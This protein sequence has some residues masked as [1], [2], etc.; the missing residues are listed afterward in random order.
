MIL[1]SYIGTRCVH[2]G[3][4]SVPPPPRLT[5]TINKLPFQSVA[6]VSITIT[7]ILHHATTT[8]FDCFDRRHPVR[9]SF[10]RGPHHLAC[11]CL[12][13]I[14]AAGSLAIVRLL[15]E[16]DECRMILFYC[17]HLQFHK[18]SVQVYRC[19]PTVIHC[20]KKQEIVIVNDV[21]KPPCL[22]HS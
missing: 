15:G 1:L 16:I 14:F 3:V 11:T 18:R 22:R 12:Q 21:S 8:L 17:A 2:M 7:I 4:I 5:S 6:T 13:F 19:M 10:S 9:L 20:I